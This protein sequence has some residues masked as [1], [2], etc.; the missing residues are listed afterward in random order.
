MPSI[1][2][3]QS[4]LQQISASPAVFDAGLALRR[5][6]T[7]R[8][9]LEGWLRHGGSSRIPA[10]DATAAAIRRFRRDGQV[11]GFAD[12]RRISFGYIDPLPGEAYRLIDDLHGFPL[13]LHHIDALRGESRRFRRCYRGLLLGYFSIDPEALH[14]NSAAR[15]NWLLLRERLREWVGEL[16]SGSIAPDWAY[17]LLRHRS[18]LTDRPWQELA[19]NAN[20]MGA[21]TFDEACSALGVPGTSWLVRRYVMQMIDDASLQNDDVFRDLLPMLLQLVEGHAFLRD[22]GLARILSRYARS[23]RTSVHPELRDFSV[24]HW[25]NPWRASN[26]DPW[27]RVAESTRAMVGAWLKRVLLEKFYRLLADRGN[28]D[29]RRLAFWL[30]YVDRIDDMHFVLGSAAFNSI[31]PE[32][33]ALRSQMRGRL[34]RLQDANPHNNAFVMAIGDYAFV[35]FGAGSNSCFVFR[36]SAG[37]P[38]ALDGQ[39]GLLLFDLKHGSRVVRLVHE[40]DASADWERR[41]EREIEFRTG[42]RPSA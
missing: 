7:Q 16:A 5:I 21:E 25:G 32:F 24:R 36:R 23:A 18:L 17:A 30:R 31:A 20:A 27:G 9:R 8:Q 14:E 19:A 41:F 6:R 10:P 13:F 29:G 4:R 37:L 40:D 34:I 42:V 22:E 15:S 2:R 39:E 33:R 12:A 1:D 11:V 38:F 3:L 35:E 28:S 26:D